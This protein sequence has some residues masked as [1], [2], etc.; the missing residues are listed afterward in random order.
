[1]FTLNS[2]QH[3]SATLSRKPLPNDRGTVNAAA[4]SN[5][6]TTTRLRLPSTLAPFFT[7]RSQMRPATMVPNAP[8]T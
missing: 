8:N 5:A 1:M 2:A 7:R 4:A 6:V 3:S